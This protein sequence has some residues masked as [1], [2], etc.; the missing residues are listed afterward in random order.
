MPIETYDEYQ[1][2]LEAEEGFRERVGALICF[3]SV[4]GTE[5]GGMTRWPDLGGFSAPIAVA[6]E[7][8]AELERRERLR[9]QEAERRARVEAEMKLQQQRLAMEMESKSKSKDRV[10]SRCSALIASGADDRPRWLLPTLLASGVLL[11]VLVVGL[12]LL[13]L[14][15]SPLAAAI[16]AGVAIVGPAVVFLV[17]RAFSDRRR[18]R[19]AMPAVT[20]VNPSGQS[21]AH[22]LAPAFASRLAAR[23]KLEHALT[24]DDDHVPLLGAQCWEVEHVLRETLFLPAV[25]LLEHLLPVIDR[26]RSE[27]LSRAMAQSPVRPTLGL[28]EIWLHGLYR[29]ATAKRRELETWQGSMFTNTPSSELYDIR[30]LLPSK[31]FVRYVGRLRETIRNPIMHGDLVAAHGETYRFWCAESYGR[32]K[33]GLWLAEGLQ[34]GRT[35][36]P[37]WVGRILGAYAPADC[38]SSN[39][40]TG[41]ADGV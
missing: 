19:P 26:R 30:V 34:P 5:N 12:V 27:I 7:L 3:E 13:L 11:V 10:I 36:G 22:R 41:Q 37:G 18:R 24:D 23:S 39:P 4:D 2:E 8:V 14:L 38:S 28:I 9:V 1:A 15:W 21:L 33:L 29:L 35:D 40:A 32:S 25:S 16:V 6:P 20:V 17:F 31:A